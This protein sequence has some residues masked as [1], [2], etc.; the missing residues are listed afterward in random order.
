MTRAIRSAW[1]SWICNW[2]Q[3]TNWMNEGNAR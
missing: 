2:W 1:W 3:R